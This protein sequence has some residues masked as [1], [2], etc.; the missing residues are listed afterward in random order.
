MYFSQRDALPC[1]PDGNGRLL[2][3]M[4]CRARKEELRRR[5]GPRAAAPQTQPAV[6]HGAPVQQSVPQQV[7]DLLSWRL[8]S[9]PPPAAGPTPVT[10][11][12]PT[13]RFANLPDVADEP[14][15]VPY[16]PPSSFF[17]GQNRGLDPRSAPLFN[18][19]DGY[20]PSNIESLSLFNFAEELSLG[21]WDPW[22]LRPPGFVDQD[23]P[24]SAIQWP[25]LSSMDERTLG[26]V[27]NAPLFSPMDE[28]NL[29]T[30]PTH[31]DVQPSP[32][33]QLLREQA[34]HPEFY[35]TDRS[36]LR[37]FFEMMETEGAERAPT[38]VLEERYVLPSFLHSREQR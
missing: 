4:L 36:T 18:P 9:P 28:H 33:D 21:L 22:H 5:A 23:V 19:L 12:G 14:L 34:L 29:D 7:Q 31:Q 6:A 25:L 10:I 15:N 11:Y 30:V 27:P 8:P 37:A 38:D 17:E 26:T 2:R 35:G 32:W 1:N 13:P 3:W 24:D 16:A 20:Y